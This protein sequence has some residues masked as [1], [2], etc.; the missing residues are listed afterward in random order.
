MSDEPA[1]LFIC[2]RDADDAFVDR[3]A[4][5]LEAETVDGTPWGRRFRVL[6]D[7]R[8]VRVGDPWQAWM[9]DG[10]RDARFMVVVVCPEILESECTLT[11]IMTHFWARSGCLLPLWVRDRRNPADA[12]AEAFSPLL[13]PLHYLD[14]RDATVFEQ[15][16]PKLLDRLRG[17]TPSQA[18]P[19]DLEELDSEVEPFSLAEA[20]DAIRE[21]LCIVFADSRGLTP[22]AVA[23]LEAR[24]F[25]ALPKPGGGTRDLQ[26]YI[27]VRSAA[28][29]CDR[30]PIQAKRLSTVEKA[31]EWVSYKAPVQGRLPPP[32]T[33]APPPVSTE[34][35]AV[36]L[37][38]AAAELGRDML[39]FAAVEIRSWS[40][41]GGVVFS[42]TNPPSGDLIFDGMPLFDHQSRLV[43]C[44]R[45]APAG[46]WLAAPFY[47]VARQNS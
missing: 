34:V 9:A 46:L 35:G 19:D 18:T 26:D 30:A 32:A 31:A 21:V 15:N 39:G 11:E 44:L 43:G 2:H 17:A 29:S 24:R 42:R 27:F 36:F 10:S 8:D 7:H 47:T 13:K 20:F 28:T 12:S 37:R 38:P 4:A 1:D 41:P 16:F 45:S 5:R 25:V 33:I 3:L 6:Y 22:V 23:W 14:F 40:M